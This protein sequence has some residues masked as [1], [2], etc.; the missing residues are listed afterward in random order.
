MV[1]LVKCWTWILLTLKHP[2]T[3]SHWRRTS[4]LLL[5][6]QIHD[7]IL[8]HVFLKYIFL[9][10]LTRCIVLALTSSW[11]FTPPPMK[12]YQDQGVSIINGFQNFISYSEYATSQYPIQHRLFVLTCELS[13]KLVKSICIPFRQISWLKL[14][15]IFCHKLE[16][17]FTS[18][19]C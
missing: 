4:I 16:E 18:R 17:L 6:P 14:K 7:F 13:Q 3:T 8:H 2:G 15:G 19:R 9:L 12:R 5:I 10:L 1:W 11:Y